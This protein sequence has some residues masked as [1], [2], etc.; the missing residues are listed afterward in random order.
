MESSFPEEQSILPLSAD[1]VE[2]LIVL[3]QSNR[4]PV[5]LDAI[6][7]LGVSGSER[8]VRPLF[9]LLWRRPGDVEIET[10]I[11]KA[12]TRIGEA[13]VMP[14]IEA[15]QSEGEVMRLKAIRVLGHL[16]DA[17]AFA[18][19]VQA[20]QDPSERV[21]N[22]VVQAISSFAPQDVVPLLCE[23]LQQGEVEVRSTAA[24]KLSTLPLRGEAALNALMAAARDP[25]PQVRRQVIR[26]LGQYHNVHVVPLLLEAMRD[27]SPWVRAEAS[28]ALGNLR[29]SYAIPLQLRALNDE[30]TLVRESAARA[31]ARFGGRQELS[32]ALLGNSFLKVSD[33]LDALETL[34]GFTFKYREFE[35][36][37][38]F[39]SV[40][41]YCRELLAAEPA[42]A[43][44]QAIE[45]VQAEI[46]ARVDRKQLLRGSQSDLSE[47]EL[48]RAH[49]GN[50]PSA[51][52]EMLRAS[53]TPPAAS[54]PP[55]SWLARLLG[56]RP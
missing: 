3:L 20:L 6:D 42:P 17:R 12:L 29:E 51:P 53:E 25:A 5:V 45:E 21:Q 28:E 32:V 9:E 14:L 54:V 38:R 10:R 27:D 43:V 22:A 52:A 8:A 13:A 39:P 44:K 41:Q 18:P 49:G 55:S 30:H 46:Q 36:D 15:L 19:L 26:A 1:Q 40:A 24:V 47:K 48:L 2:P 4:K 50:A 11:T 35:L 16:A 33:K 31:L 7:V 34:S 23:A 37:Y 56:R